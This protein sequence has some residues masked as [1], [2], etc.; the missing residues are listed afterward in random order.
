MP[1]SDAPVRPEPEAPDSKRG[2][3]RGP[4]PDAKRGR[5]WWNRRPRTGAKNGGQN[6]RPP[7]TPEP[8]RGRDQGKQTGAPNGGARR[9]TVPK[10][11][12]VM[13]VVLV[14][15]TVVTGL[16][17]LVF[18]YGN[19][20]STLIGLGWETWLA[21]LYTPAVDVTVITLILV[22]QYLA[23]AGVAQNRLR[24]PTWLL[25]G[26]GLAMLGANVVPSLI[27]GAVKH[28]GG[29]YGRALADAVLPA[30]LI[31]WSHIGPYLLTLFT[32]IRTEAEAAALE[33]QERRTWATEADRAEAAAILENA[34]T[35]AERIRAA[36][37]EEL[38]AAASVRQA[39]EAAAVAAARQR[40]AAARDLD[41]Q[42]AERE[43][44][45][46]RQLAD[47]ER[48]VGTE[49]AGA[50][51]EAELLA[52]RAKR[53]L[54]EA[55]RMTASIGDQVAAAASDLKRAE[56]ERRA[57][58]EDRQAAEEILAAAEQAARRP[59]PAHA[60][61]PDAEPDR[62]TVTSTSG[63]LRIEQRIDLWVKAHP[64]WKDQ[65]VPD[66]RAVMDF[67]PGLTSGDTIS[68]F[69]KKIEEMK[70]AA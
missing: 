57:A 41:D 55:E 26:A 45:A 31:A 44:M 70:A 68:K 17:S 37:S 53:E 1:R 4:K 63:R 66:Q 48:V 56:A 42:L 8:E 46:A 25:A 52:A 9:T 32:E 22:L 33:V 24:K 36:A 30:I 16:A 35:E 20:R 12:S 65:A 49:A 54:A 27:T 28:Q 15:A 7:E 18:S 21:S 50:M 62:E 6:R 39:E 51:R 29:A 60:D 19:V 69:R 11:H 23:S 59:R 58:A 43:R 47:R 14:V 64:E 10:L 38:A 13:L 3:N 40:T 5:H 61:R 34:H 67:F 2:R